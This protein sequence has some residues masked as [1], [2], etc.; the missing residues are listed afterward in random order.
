MDE[1]QKKYESKVKTEWLDDATCAAWRKWHDKSVIFWGELTRAQLAVSALTP[2]QRVLDLASGTG[3]PALEVARIVG[4]SGHVAVTDLAPQMLEIAREQAAR[5][6]LTNLSYEVVD[7][8]EMPFPDA[9]FDRVTCRLGVMFFWDCQKALREIRR[10]LKPGGIASF[11]AWG[12]LDRNEYMK[13]V[14]GPFHRRQPLPPPQPG[15]T[16]PA[17][18]GT[19]GSLSAELTTAGFASVTEESL[20]VSMRWPGPPEELWVRQYEISAPLRPYFDSFAPAEKA[21]AV[22]E[23]IGG[24]H[25]RYDGGHVTCM[26]AIVVAS[27]A[28]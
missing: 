19:P 3:D 20:T 15:A 18:F 22:K 26:T 11:V 12:P 14:T 8:H 17:R 21:A 9:S 24:L 27:A 1:L 6:H 13:V 5:A 10:V 28:R 23:V 25:Q 2:G 7:A 4:P 16:H